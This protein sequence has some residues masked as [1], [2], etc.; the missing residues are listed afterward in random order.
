MRTLERVGLAL[1]AGASV[2]LATAPASSAAPDCTGAGPNVTFC[3]TKG[4][5]QLTTT[6]PPWNYGGWTGVGMWPL[7]GPYGIGW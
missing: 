7:V 6:P 4:S 1:I 3:Q 2:A 5:T